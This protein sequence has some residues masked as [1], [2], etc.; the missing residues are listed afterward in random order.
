MLPAENI[1]DNVFNEFKVDPFLKRL[2]RGVIIVGA[3]AS[4]SFRSREMRVQAA[5]ARSARAAA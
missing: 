1:I 3:V 2:L 4:Y 5:S